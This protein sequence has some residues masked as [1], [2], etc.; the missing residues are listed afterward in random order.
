MP[1]HFTSGRPRLGGPEKAD[2]SDALSGRRG[3]PILTR[4]QVT[5]LRLFGQIA[6]NRQG[7]F[8]G[9]F[10]VSGGKEASGIAWSVCCKG[11][12][13]IANSL[14]SVVGEVEMDAGKCRVE[15]CPE[16]GE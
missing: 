3:N 8:H 6:E 11:V 10:W 5:R 2:T 7:P 4:D 1:G 13:V 12:G 14:I 16:A 15:W 9:L